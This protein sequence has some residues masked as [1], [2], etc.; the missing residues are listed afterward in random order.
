M[1]QKRAFP[2]EFAV[3]TPALD[4]VAIRGPAIKAAGVGKSAGRT[5]HRDPRR[6]IYPKLRKSMSHRIPAPTSD[7]EARGIS[8]YWFAQSPPRPSTPIPMGAVGNARPRGMAPGPPTERYGAENGGIKT[9]IRN[10][11]GPMAGLLF[12]FRRRPSNAVSRI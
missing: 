12:S 10:F 2:D 3:D 4:F 6:F 7:V 11:R 5:R 8:D 9:R 1:R